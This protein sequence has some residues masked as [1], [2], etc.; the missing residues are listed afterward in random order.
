MAEINTDIEKAVRLLNEDELVAIPTETVYG[1]AGNALSK[2]AVTKIFTVKN[3]PQF[4][5]LIIHVPDLEKA[6][7]YVLEIPDA[8]Q[9]LAK[10]FWPGPLT[11]LLKKKSIIP[12][13]VTQ[14][15]IRLACDVRIIF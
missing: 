6:R 2:T 13:L 9:T 12:D 14:D 8:A 15:W 3:R 7:D 5:P 1:L 11:L 4:D 10:K